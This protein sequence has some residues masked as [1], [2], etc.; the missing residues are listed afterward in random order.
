MR[1][2]D[3]KS[4]LQNTNSSWQDVRS[5]PELLTGLSSDQ[6]MGYGVVRRAGCQLYM[7]I[8][9]GEERNGKRN[10]KSIHRSDGREGTERKNVTHDYGQALAIKVLG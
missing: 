9:V 6:G 7:A 8:R 2:E 4:P 3:V 1:Q 10:A 5:L